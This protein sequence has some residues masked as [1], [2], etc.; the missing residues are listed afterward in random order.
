MMLHVPQALS[1]DALAEVRRLIGAGPWV[2]G[3]ETS[4]PQAALAKDNLQLAQG[5][6]AEAEAGALVL[7]ALARAPL[8]QAGALPARIWPPMF[9]RYGPGRKFDAHVDNAVR[10]ALGGPRVRADVSATLFLSDPGDYEGGELVVEDTFGLH[11]V[12]LPA[13]DLVLYPASSLHRVQPIVSG[14]RSA[15]ILWVQSLVRDDARRALLLDMDLAIQSAAG[16]LGQS[17]PAVVSLTGAYHNLV[18][19]WADL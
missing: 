13:G 15:V 19:M 10:G 9:N 18:R 4:G 3:N 11:E 12:K 2:D 16:R 8:F 6:P 14:E 1:A 5:S 7:A 17:D